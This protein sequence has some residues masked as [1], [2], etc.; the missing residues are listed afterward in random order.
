MTDLLEFMKTTTIGDLKDTTTVIY[1]AK[2]T[3]PAIVSL[4]KLIDHHILSMPVWDEEKKAFTSFIDIM[5]VLTFVVK[6]LFFSFLALHLMA[7]YA[8]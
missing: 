5:D 3:D 7:E 8:A 2:S 4:R 6:A 1:S